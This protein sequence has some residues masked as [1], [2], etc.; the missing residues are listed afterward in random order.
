MYRPATMQ[1]VADDVVGKAQRKTPL[2]H[3]H[4]ASAP[5]E[6]AI[7]AAV[8]RLFGV[9]RPSHVSRL[10][11]F[12]VIDAIDG[13]PWRWLLAHI[14]KEGVEGLA[15]FSTHAYSAGAVPEVTGV[16]WLVASAKNRQPRTVLWRPRSAVRRIAAAQHV[17]KQASARLLAAICEVAAERYGPVPAIANAFPPRTAA[18]AS[19]VCHNGEASKARTDAINQ[20]CHASDNRI[21]RWRDGEDVTGEGLF[22]GDY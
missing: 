13:V 22:Y 9:C 17:R 2:R 6:N 5:F 14:S 18:C 8:V 15:P 1:P 20:C 21:A 7:S 16:V 4:C 12:S 11:A 3:R 19:G 10:V